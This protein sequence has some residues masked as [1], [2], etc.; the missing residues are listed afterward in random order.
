M[1]IL[2]VF[3]K[4]VASFAHMDAETGS[5]MDLGN[6]ATVICPSILYARGR[7]AMRDETFSGLRV[8]TTLLEN[9]DE[10]FT[11]PEEFLPILHDQEYFANSLDL[12]SKEFLKKCDMYM[13]LKNSGRSMPGTPYPNQGNT[14]G[15]QQQPRYHPINSP[16]MERP[17][18]GPLFNGSGQPNSDRTG[19]PQQHQQNNEYYP[20]PNSPP[21]PQG[22]PPPGMLQNVQRNQ[23]AEQWTPAPPSRPND[24][25]G[26]PKSRP[27]SFV[28]PPPRPP[29]PSESLQT[30]SYSTAP[31]MNGN[32]YP[33][34]A[35][36]RQRI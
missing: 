14:G 3:L 25:T 18:P 30:H 15:G 35:S 29:P 11:V 7:D 4:W 6:L 23:Q 36:G 26:S 21:L 17:S 9:Q 20:P 33:A 34:A 19:R 16:T 12:P 24:A 27:S 5:K 10:V 2:F 13:R 1:E 28:G 32:G 22:I 31:A 8:I